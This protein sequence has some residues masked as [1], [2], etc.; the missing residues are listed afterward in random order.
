MF[1]YTL[2]VDFGTKSDVWIFDFYYYF[3]MQHED[4]DMMLRFIILD[5]SF[6]AYPCF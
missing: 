3:Q 4:L 1:N 6:V 2:L 5:L